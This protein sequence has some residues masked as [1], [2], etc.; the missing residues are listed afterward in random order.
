M[1]TC[2]CAVYVCQGKSEKALIVSEF[3]PNPRTKLTRLSLSKY[4]AAQGSHKTNKTKTSTLCSGRLHHD[5]VL[6]ATTSKI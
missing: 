6:Q 1:V 4:F 3:T 5:A 2:V